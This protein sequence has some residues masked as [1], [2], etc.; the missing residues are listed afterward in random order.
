MNSKIPY[1]T[2]ADIADGL[3]ARCEDDIACIAEQLDT[4]P[5]DIRD[6]LI[7]SDLLNAYQAFYYFFRVYPGD[8]A[9]EILML[10]PS[11][12]VTRGIMMDE[13]DLLELVFSVLNKVP[14][15]SVTD[16]AVVLASFQGKNAYLQARS[17][18][19]DILK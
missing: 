4:F 14:Q 16:G 9:E 7:V 10:Q 11:G 8:I 13:I 3:F 2:L 15:I 18:I 5:P 19:E 17:F 6:E 1:D 12:N